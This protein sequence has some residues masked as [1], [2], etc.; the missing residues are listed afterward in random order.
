VRRYPVIRTLTPRLTDRVRVLNPGASVHTIPLALDL[1]LY[2]FGGDDRATERPVIALIGSFD[3]QPTRSAATRLL[4]RLWPEIKRRVPEAR[5]QI[6]GRSAR[7]VLGDALPPDVAVHENFPDAMP[8]FRRTDVLLYAPERGSGMKVKVLEA[9]A[10]GVPV[11]T[12]EDGVEGVAARD[13]VHAGVCDDDAGLIDR[14]VALLRDRERAR[15]QSHAARALV[16]ATCS[17]QANLAAL[18]DV[19]ATILDHG[20][21]PAAG[22]G[23]A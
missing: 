1:S 5:L 18:E 3:W 15:R 6:V 17:P 21:S 2:P 8:Y 22:P 20:R 11:V 14:C 16:D 4:T 9:F 7:L 13:G 19:Y 23:R 10:L 12:T